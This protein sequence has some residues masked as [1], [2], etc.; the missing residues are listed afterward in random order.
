LGQF[1]YN[2][3]HSLSRLG[4][5][6]PLRAAERADELLDEGDAERAA[7]WRAI[8]GA[9]KELQRGRREDEAPLL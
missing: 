8:M 6:V 2:G 4:K 3:E 7:I 5:D 9:I 1:H